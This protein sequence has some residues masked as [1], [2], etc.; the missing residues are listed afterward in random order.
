MN[1]TTTY[2]TLLIQRKIEHTGEYESERDKLV[3]DLEDQGWN[4]NIESEDDD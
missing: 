2:L 3:E 1:K 4:V